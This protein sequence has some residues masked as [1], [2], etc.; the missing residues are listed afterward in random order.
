MVPFL[1][2]LVYKWTRV[3][4]TP[5][6]LQVLQ[7]EPRGKVPDTMNT[8]D[9]LLAKVAL[10]TRTDH[11]QIEQVMHVSFDARAALDAEFGAGNRFSISLARL[12][13]RLNHS[14]DRRERIETT[15]RVTELLSAA[16]DQW[17][18]RRGKYMKRPGAD[19]VDTE[20]GGTPAANGL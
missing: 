9:E 7:P 20:M 14:L 19:F 18:R 3:L 16:S 11:Y 8:F 4:E 5:G 1:E 15:F 17:A 2:S 12:M 10:L 6:T 13:L